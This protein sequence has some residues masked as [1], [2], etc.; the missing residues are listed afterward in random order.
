[1]GHAEDRR[2][3]PSTPLK[4]PTL[5]D[6]LF[7]PVPPAEVEAS[8][9]L[10]LLR[11]PEWPKAEP[12]PDLDFGDWFPESDFRPQR[13]VRPRSGWCVRPLWRSRSTRWT[14]DLPQSGG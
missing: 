4:K 10:D 1:M 6:D 12:T 5:P 2:D 14:R 8:D 7:D 11:F 3:L 9:D 13:E